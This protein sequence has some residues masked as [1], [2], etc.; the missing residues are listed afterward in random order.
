MGCL[1]TFVT[2][3]LKRLEMQNKQIRLYNE[4]GPCFPK[5]IHLIPGVVQHELDAV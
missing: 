1:K 4:R 3:I 5:E 2:D